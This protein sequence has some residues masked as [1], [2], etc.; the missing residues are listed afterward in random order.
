MTDK[1]EAGAQA[2]GQESIAESQVAEGQ[3]E[4]QEAGGEGQ[5]Q[6]QQAE[7]D[8]APDAL[9]MGWTPREQFKGDPA[10]WV[11]A[12]TFVE[13]G[14]TFVPFLK[15]S[16]RKLQDRL[17]KTESEFES[18]I[19]R[20]EAAQERREKALKTIYD[21]RLAR[22]K[23]DQRKAA[24]EGDTAAYD[25]LDKEREAVARQADEAFAAEKTEPAK[26]NAAIEKAWVA[27]NQWYRTDYKLAA[28]ARLY[29]Q[30]LA[31][32]N[33]GLT[34][35]ENLKATAQ[36]IREEHPD[37]F[38]GKAKP[39]GNGHAAVDG[40]SSFPA[41]PFGRKAA[42]G[43][44]DLPAEAKEMCARDVADK[45]YKDRDEWAKEYWKNG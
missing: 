34:L 17:A 22:I 36:H 28:E 40:G 37:K 27:E 45:L 24:A 16:N 3:A 44:A 39:K 38:G 35:A 31:E 43:Y 9:E 33:D 21:D 2:S 20:M 7:R 5:Q 29:S 1:P 19:K 12:K 42:K 13:R 8:Y 18:R 26:D 14:E 41:T 6:E 11:D 30:W 4:Q 15:A 25:A 32:N 10:K 23:A